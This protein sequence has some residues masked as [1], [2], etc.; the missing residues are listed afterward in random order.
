MAGRTR[1]GTSNPETNE[2]MTVGRRG[3]IGAGLATAGAAVLAP[4]ASAAP[5]RADAAEL[6]LS[7]KPV[8]PTAQSLV[9]I[10]DGRVRAAVRHLDDVIKEVQKRTG[11]PGIAASVVH[12]G[13]M[14]YAKGFGVRDVTTGVPV[15]AQTVFHLASVSKSLSATVVARIV[16]RNRIQWDDPIIGHLRDF[17]LSD[18]YVTRHVTYA[19]M[20]SHTSG[21]PQYAGDL[22]EDLGYPRRYILHALRHQPLHAFRSQYAYTNF[23]L[24]A[25]GV[26]AAS[27]AG[28]EWAAVAD[29][30]AVRAAA[31]EEEHVPLLAV[32]ARAQSGRH[33]RADQRQVVPEVHA[34][35]GPRGP[36]RR[37]SL[38]RDR[39]CEMDD[40]EAR[41]R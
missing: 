28:G 13:Q 23:G 29:E 30:S 27:A 16:G 37:R 14:L 4:R 9:M 3:F 36:R 5:P 38:E 31:D 25:A 21:L 6:R 17:R 24:T 18:R 2:S 22:L 26:A 7:P 8:D 40:A 35:R 34:Q 11:V 39:P 33:A 32:R 15:N 12:G 19:D 20:F 41:R 1:S 10:P